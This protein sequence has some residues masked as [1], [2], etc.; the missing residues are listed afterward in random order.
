MIHTGGT[1]QMALHYYCR[2][3]GTK[4]GVIDKHSLYSHQLGFQ[5]L[6][7]TE[8]DEM[9]HYQNNGDIH[10][11]TICEDCHEALQRN[12]DYHGLDKF[13]Q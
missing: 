12:P 7:E 10:V 5:Q 2:H 9:I 1:F 6:T 11:Q 3:C 13:I 4:V 8:R